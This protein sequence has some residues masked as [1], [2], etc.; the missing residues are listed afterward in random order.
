MSISIKQLKDDR[1][2][3]IRIIKL[4]DGRK[5][6]LEITVCRQYE[7]QLKMVK[8]EIE[9]LENEDKRNT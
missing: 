4:F 6:P 1:G 7:Q 3:L 9:T 2:F 8:E 5:S